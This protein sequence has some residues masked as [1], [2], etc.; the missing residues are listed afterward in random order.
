MIL[1]GVLL[2]INDVCAQSKKVSFQGIV[3]DSETTKPLEMVVVSIQELNLWTVTDKKGKFSFS[4][5]PS[6]NY[7][8]FSSCLGYNSY[9]KSINISE[10]TNGY[11][12]LLI[13]QSLA[14]KEI[15]VTAKERTGLGSS[16]KIDKQA[17]EHIQPVTLSDVMQL[18]PG[19]ISLNPNLED[20]N[21]ISIR[22]IYGNQKN[23]DKMGALGTAIFI[24]GTPVSNDANMQS[25]NTSRK[26]GNIDFSTA[27][28]AGT[29]LRQI[30]IDNIESVEVVRGVA[31][32]EY[33]EMTSGA[34]LLKTKAG[35]SPLKAQ[36]K[37][38]PNIKSFH[39]GKGYLI[40]SKSG[41][42]NF[43]VNYTHSYDD[44]RT[45][46]KS[47]NLFNG[48]I[49][50]SNVF[51]KGKHP[52]SFNS[53]LNIYSSKDEVNNDKNAEVEE[54]YRSQDKGWSLNID[55]VWSLNKSWITNISYTFSTSSSKQTSYIKD[56]QSL[57]GPTPVATSINSGT[58]Q[59]IYLDNGYYS[60]LFIEGKPF[61]LFAKVKASLAGKY[62]NVFNKFFV[63][64]EWRTNGN[65][66]KGRYF[67]MEK[68][69]VPYANN[70]IRPRSFKD[71]PSLSQY[72]LFAE[73]KIRLS[74]SSTFLDIQA[75][76]RLNNL[77]PDGLFGTDFKVTCEPRLNMK[78]QILGPQNNN[79]FKEL[80]VSGGYGIHM[81]NPSIIHF[82]PDKAYFDI[83][84]FDYYPQLVVMETHVLENTGNDDLKPAKNTKKEIGLDI[85]YKQV[86]LSVTGFREKLKNGFALDEGF[87]I[88]E[89]KKYD[90]LAADMNPV[91]QNGMVMVDGV[92]HTYT[93][94]TVF[95]RYQRT[96]NNYSISKRGIEYYLDLGKIDIL[97]TSVIIDGAYIST[98]KIK[99]DVSQYYPQTTWDGK[100]YPFVGI[101]EKGQYEKRK[102]FN[103]N[104]RLVTHIPSVKMVLS[105]T[106]QIIWNES[107]RILYENSE[108][109]VVPYMYDEN[110]NKVTGETVYSDS[111]NNKYVN[112]IAFMDKEGN[113]VEFSDG[114]ESEDIYNSLILSKHPRRYLNESLP[115]V[116]Q[117]NLRLSK[118]IGDNM[119][120]SFFAN[121]VFSNMPLTRYRR[122]DTYF[123]RNSP[124]YF[125]AELKLKL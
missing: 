119:N 117:I 65:D 9:K 43:D 97:K 100:K 86:S 37:M 111:E 56:F 75:G 34:V 17:L 59:G 109:D 20:I 93:M 102:R 74:I 8:L 3:S 71:V 15:T 101:Y 11:T 99:Q 77:R 47:F 80:S 54:V 85:K 116:V 50:Y 123:R 110:G 10:N 36:L 79:I 60:N 66:G 124:F 22:E 76:I 114:F 112:P 2:G 23:I 61:N 70:A 45:R 14:L 21:Q 95:N 68:P 18:V 38:D 122:S 19:H 49:A 44:I 25:L 27:V 33:G 40:D 88:M 51:F 92:A 118:D 64:F 29:D 6:G 12:L 105:T 108:G 113:I 83:K 120:L 48:Q 31:S 4:D 94:D 106:A 42:L 96:N 73:D 78:Y 57:S 72:S 1:L 46:A 89:Y 16:S 52:L 7:T 121:N 104:F 28:G 67:D 87:D 58:Y 125:G 39:V 90:A 103:T 98:K 26:I 62:G 115:T 82:F 35:R 41:A 32:S 5:V 13:K 81:K 91:F 24:N 69:Y 55:G 53:R 63:G 30:S 84:S 107:M